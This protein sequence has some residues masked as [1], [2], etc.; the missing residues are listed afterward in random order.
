AY[1]WRGWAVGVAAGGGK[2]IAWRREGDNLKRDVRVLATA[3]APRSDVLY[4]R[5]TAEGGERYRFAFSADGREWTDVGGW[6]DGAF[7]EGARVALTAAGG[8]ARFDWV[9]VTPTKE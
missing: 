2:V 4:L 6:T 5:M 9:R 8:A 1:A 3:E 7:I